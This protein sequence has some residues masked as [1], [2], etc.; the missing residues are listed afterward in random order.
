MIRNRALRDLVSDVRGRTRVRGVE[1][2]FKPEE[3]VETAAVS[4]LYVRLG[5]MMRSSQNWR[6]FG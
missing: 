2:I 1:M 3:S 5:M 6:I 4:K